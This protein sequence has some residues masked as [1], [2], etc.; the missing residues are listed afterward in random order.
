M[1]TSRRLVPPAPAP[2]ARRHNRGCHDG[3]VLAIAELLTDLNDATAALV[4]SLDGLTDAEAREP[5]RLP[6]WSRGHV[7]THLARNAEGGTRLLTWA[8]TGE[9]SYEYR[10]VAARAQAIEDGAGR[11]AAELVEDVKRTAHAM[12]TAAKDMPR[13]AW[14]HKISWT[15]GQQTPAAHVPESRLAEVLIHHVDLDYG[16]EPGAWPKRWTAQMLDR[17]VQSMNDERHLAP[18]TATLHGTDTGRDFRLDRPDGTERSQHISG[19]EADIL[20]W[21][22]GRSTGVALTTDPPSG[23]PAVPSIYYT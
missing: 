18:L 23:L 17:A 16:Y 7:L 3:G 10:S 8:R 22:M 21:L 2:G 1:I 15:T 6:G 4:T 19:T 9:P 13:E 11:P 12:A 5:S 20:A 14:P